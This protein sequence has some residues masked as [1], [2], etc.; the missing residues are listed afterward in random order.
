M[1]QHSMWITHLALT[2]R[3]GKK[4]LV[5]RALILTLFSIPFSKHRL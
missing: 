1:L 3:S 4:R 2:L 5:L